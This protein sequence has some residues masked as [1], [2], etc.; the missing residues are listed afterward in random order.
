MQ[1][2]RQRNIEA[3]YMREY[4]LFS[5]LSEERIRFFQNRLAQSKITN[6]NRDFYPIG[7]YYDMVLWS[8]FFKYNLKGLFGAINAK[9]IYISLIF[10]CLLLLIPAWIRS[11]RRGIPCWGV[12]ACVGTTGFAEMT[13]QIITLLSF[14]VLYGFVYYKLGVILTSFM[15][16]LI[17]GGWWITKRIEI[18]QADYNL[19]IKTQ[20]AIFIYPLILPLLFWAF[21]VTKGR[22][23]LFL[24]TNVI[25]PFLPVIPGVIGGIQFPLAN[26]LYIKKINVGVG[27]SAGLTYGIDLFGSC[28]GAILTSILLIPIIGIP[29]TCLLVAGLNLVGLIL[30]LKT[31]L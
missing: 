4:Y 16:G 19:F 25:F 10:F 11:V 27:S 18:G 2:L 5:E 13:F 20:A 22:F 1:R 6:L 14:Q 30:L 17:L 3:R 21:S 31:K 9:K 12:L 23:S 28:L 15:F 29:M 24:G 7:Y 8:T 26:S